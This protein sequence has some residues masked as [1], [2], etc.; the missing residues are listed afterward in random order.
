MPNYTLSR[1]HVLVTLSGRAI[2]F[3]KGQPTHVPQ[4]CVRDAVAIGAVPSDGS[5]VAKVF[6]ADEDSLPKAPTNPA[7][8][9][10]KIMNSMRLLIERND[11][12]D[13]SASGLPN[14]KVLERMLGWKVDK[15]ELHAVWMS[16]CTEQA[17]I[18]NQQILEART[19]A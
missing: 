18:K 1:T 4:E 8:R 11:R 5:D 10:E 16:Y 9:Q 14:L 3:K 13:F 12:D 2:E 15:K 19:G 6:E 17:E 7:E